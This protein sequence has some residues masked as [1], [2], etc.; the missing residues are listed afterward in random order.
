M[1]PGWENTLSLDGAGQVTYFKPG[2]DRL[3]DDVGLF[4][5]WL[6]ADEF[7]LVLLGA[8]A[9]AQV[10]LAPAPAPAGPYD[11]RVTLSI[12]AG[13]HLR[14]RGN[15]GP[16]SG[17]HRQS[18]GP[19]LHN[20]CLGAPAAE[21]AR[22]QFSMDSSAAHPALAARRGSGRARLPL[23]LAQS[24]PGRTAAGDARDCA[25]VE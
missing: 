3:G 11:V 7:K 14:Y 16:E 24:R 10:T 12:L 8:K 9:I 17:R 13:G 20:D 18:Q 23:A 1:Q 15:L 25:R 6:P 2:S 21:H 22:N 4:R 19:R 5:A